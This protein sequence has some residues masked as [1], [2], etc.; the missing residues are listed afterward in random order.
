MEV[1]EAGRSV[2]HAFAGR[3]GQQRRYRPTPGQVIAIP[4]PAGDIETWL[5]SA[6]AGDAALPLV[7]DFHGG[8]LGA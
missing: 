6:G 3:L 7:I 2:P 4:G 5:F 1:M 8:P